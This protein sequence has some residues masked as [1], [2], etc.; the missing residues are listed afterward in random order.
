M[1]RYRYP[2]TTL[3][4]DYLRVAFGVAISGGP[5]VALDLAPAVAVLLAALTLLFLWFGVRTGLRQLSW[6]ELSAAEIALGGPLRRRLSWQEVR[7][8]QLAYYA[9]RRA[10][11]DGWLQLTL[12]GPSGPALRVELDAGG[13]RCRAAAG[14]R[15]R[16]AQ[17]SAARPG[18][19]SQSRRA[20]ARRGG[21]G[22]RRDCCV[23]ALAACS[24]RSGRARARRGSLS[25]RSSSSPAIAGP[26]Q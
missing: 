25:Q 17:R 24:T 1:E 16:R 13:L 14:D 26:N 15:R 19:G 20:R 9:P 21:R 2:A 5:L 6:V 18:D 7:R 23:Q 10:R 12:R 8:L 11:Q 4:P 3:I 22:R